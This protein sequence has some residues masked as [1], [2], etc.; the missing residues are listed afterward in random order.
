MFHR[1]ILQVPARILVSLGKLS[2]GDYT[3]IFNSDYL[4]KVNSIHYSIVDTISIRITGETTVTD[5]L[6]LVSMVYPVSGQS[7]SDCR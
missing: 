1:L 5:D 2:Q 4:D 7:F 3:L 6:S